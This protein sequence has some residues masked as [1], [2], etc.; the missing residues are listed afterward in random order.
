[1]P[2][3]LYASCPLPVHDLSELSVGIGQLG[4]LCLS[5]E[6]AS[7]FPTGSLRP[8][9]RDVPLTID[10]GEL[11]QWSMMGSQSIMPDAEITDMN[12]VEQPQYEPQLWD[13]FC[14][15]IWWR[16]LLHESMRCFQASTGG[17]R[18]CWSG[19]SLCFSEAAAV[20]AAAKCQEKNRQLQALVAASTTWVATRS[21]EL[22]Y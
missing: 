14:I 22:L 20:T 7:H 8:A 15:F 11:Y 5:D 17:C 13:V 10:H 18:A 3:V 16:P 19:G 6:M 4:H 1:M 21:T 9:F 12:N 2:D